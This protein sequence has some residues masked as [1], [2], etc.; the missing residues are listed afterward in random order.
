MP[1]PIKSFDAD[2]DATSEHRS[3]QQSSP[4][5]ADLPVDV[6]AKW[7]LAGVILYAVVRGLFAAATKPFWY[8]ELC[9][10]IIVKQGSISAMWHALSHGADGQPLPYYLVERL[11]WAVTNN[12]HISFRIP[13]ILGFSCVIFC[14]YSFVRKKNGGTVALACAMIPL[15]TVLFDTY[16]VE[17][18][19]YSLMVACISV[20]LVCYQHAPSVRWMILMGASFALAQSF[21]Y[22]SVISFIPFVAAELVFA[23]GARRIRWAVWLAFSCGLLPLIL[24]WPLLSQ[25]RSSH[26]AHF[27]AVPSLE[28]AKS[29]YG[30]YF[31][32]SGFWGLVLLVAAMLAVLGTLLLRVRKRAEATRPVVDLL[33]EPILILGF[34]ALP[35]IGFVIA[36][37]AHGG[38][39]P[40]Y[41]LSALF[42]FPLAASYLLPRIR[43]NSI[44]LFAMLV[45]LSFFVIHEKRFWF[46]YNAH[47][48]SPA[49]SVEALA[50]SAG[51]SALPVVVSNAHD[52]LQLAYYAP[53]EWNQRFISLVD[54]PEAVIYSGSDSADKELQAMRE[55]AP[56]RVYDFDKFAVDH[57]SFLLYSSIAGAGLDW[58]GSKLFRD[59]YSFKMVAQKDFYHRIFLVTKKDTAH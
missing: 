20:A 38:M 3:V 34:L 56:L 53:P 57:H 59:G 18:R 24:F 30:W 27:W 14:L 42:G 33:H 39:T 47:F 54:P 22:Y 28:S 31:N 21:H 40:R 50:A 29:G 5:P 45:L 1:P 19:P 17:A 58:W 8:D 15:F 44:G 55:F 52:Y 48:I 25:F 6:L 4:L 23:L 41:V 2:F 36:K 49:D 35:L 26:G 37:L 16:A 43:L 51:H 9:T 32:T 46:S 11:A 13:S 7:L 10:L 12:Q